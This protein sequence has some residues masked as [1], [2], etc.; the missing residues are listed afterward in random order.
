MSLWLF[1]EL[2]ICRMCNGAVSILQILLCLEHF[3]PPTRAWRRQ[4][5][6]T[7]CLLVCFQVMRLLWVEGRV[8]R[9]G[10]QSLASPQGLA[11]EDVLDSGL[12]PGDFKGLQ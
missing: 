3:I 12:Y 8:V 2:C 5:H 7:A 6:C 11:R 1:Y 4:G 10:L 9:V